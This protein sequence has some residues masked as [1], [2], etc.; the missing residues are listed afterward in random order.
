M[1]PI[2]IFSSLLGRAKREVIG[3][4]DF[5]QYMFRRNPRDIIKTFHVVHS[6]FPT[7]KIVLNAAEGKGSFAKIIDIPGP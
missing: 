4:R 2:T 1:I 5:Y 3:K 7:N 6:A